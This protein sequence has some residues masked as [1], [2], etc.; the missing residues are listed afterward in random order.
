[1]TNPPVL[2][3]HNNV[4]QKTRLCLKTGL[5]CH[6][7]LLGLTLTLMSTFIVQWICF[8][9]GKSIEDTSTRHQSDWLFYVCPVDQLVQIAVSHIVGWL[10]LRKRLALVSGATPPRNSEVITIIWVGCVR[11]CVY[12]IHNK[13][14]LVPPL[15][16][17]FQLYLHHPQN[18]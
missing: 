2:F 12:V 13:N 14:R 18:S 4:F 10:T 16:S 3:W 11:V 8:S 1:M 5:H 6:W 9:L 15:I 7:R 17:T